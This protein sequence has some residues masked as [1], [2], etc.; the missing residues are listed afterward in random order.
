ME[1]GKKGWVPIT[2]S[3]WEGSQSQKTSLQS[4]GKAAQLAKPFTGGVVLLTWSLKQEHQTSPLLGFIS[5]WFLEG[6]RGHARYELQLWMGAKFGE[7][8]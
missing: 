3:P 1:S 4:E 8:N 7:G 6:C 2:A 5:K